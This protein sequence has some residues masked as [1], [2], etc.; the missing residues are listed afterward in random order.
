MA[1]DNTRRTIALG[2]GATAASTFIPALAFA[3]EGAQQPEGQPGEQNPPS[4]QGFSEE[5]V[6][7]RVEGINELRS[8]SAPGQSML[9]VTLNINREIDTAA[10]D[11]RDRVSSALRRLPND[12]EPPMIMKQD[13]D[14]SPVLSIAIS[15]NL[16]VRELT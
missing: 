13:S 14:N 8:V 15:G 4:Q 6:V 1:H 12:I 3:Q 5:E 11:V 2:L 16:S 7:N 9:N 10:Q